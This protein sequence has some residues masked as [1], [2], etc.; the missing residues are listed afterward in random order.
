M[1]T[2]RYQPRTPSFIELPSPDPRAA[3]EFYSGLFGWRMDGRIAHLDD[4]PVAV[5]SPQHRPGR[6]GWLTYV[7]V[8]DLTTTTQAVRALGADVIIRAANPFGA[9]PVA[10]CA[11]P[12]GAVF[13]VWQPAGQHIGARARRPGSVSRIELETRQ[14]QAAI[15]FYP[16]VF[17]WTVNPV[18]VSGK[19]L[20]DWQI[21]GATIAGLMPMD[22]SVPAEVPS[23]WMVYFDV[24]DPDAAA[25]R[26]WQL[27]GTVFVPPTDVEVGRF[28]V[29]GD[30]QGAVFGVLRMG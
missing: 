10:V 29:L 8:D 20:Y 25:E 19:H 6:P 27:G 2:M 18:R 16:T 1:T 26:T 4:E 11:D 24:A 7:A 14:P 30:A 12:T 5:L 23:H 22:D 21:D 9:G 28:A 3:V 17:G 15:A 13:G